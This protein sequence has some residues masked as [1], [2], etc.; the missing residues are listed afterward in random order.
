MRVSA[1]TGSRTGESTE[2]VPVFP[3]GQMAPFVPVLFF[4]WS[5]PWARG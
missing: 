1:S 5:L 4:L 2:G 3:V